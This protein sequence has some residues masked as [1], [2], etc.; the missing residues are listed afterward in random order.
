MSCGDNDNIAINSTNATPRAWSGAGGFRITDV[1]VQ[2]QT[3]T[4]IIYTTSSTNSGNMGS[5]WLF[6][7]CNV[8]LFNSLD[9]EGIDI[10]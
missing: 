1:D 9:L 10:S 8:F 4:A 2:Y 5:N 7:E 6:I 3:G